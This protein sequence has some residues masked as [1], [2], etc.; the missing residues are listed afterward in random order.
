VLIKCLTQV[1]NSL[2]DLLATS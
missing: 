2:D 1:H